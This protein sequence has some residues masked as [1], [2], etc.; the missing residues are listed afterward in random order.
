MFIAEQASAAPQP[1]AKQQDISSLAAT[2]AAGTTYPTFESQNRLLKGI[3]E[4]ITRHT[5]KSKQF[6]HHNLEARSHD[7]KIVLTPRSKAIIDDECI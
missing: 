4:D 5:Y 7:H 2:N 6:D 1:P 3:E